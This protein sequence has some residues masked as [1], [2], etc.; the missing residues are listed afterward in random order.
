MR[1]VLFAIVLAACGG[2]PK[3]EDTRPVAADKPTGVAGDASCPL[4]VPGTSISVEDAEEGPALVF[5]TTGDVTAVRTRGLAL[6][7]MH[8]AKD[9]GADALGMMFGAKS[10]AKATDIEGGVRVTFTPADP[11]TA[12]AVGNELRMH[13]GHL[14]GASSCAM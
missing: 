4:L 12:D 5:V 2:S 9:G 10:T 3:A 13:A 8:N 7:T 14:A 1:N 11:A 6:A